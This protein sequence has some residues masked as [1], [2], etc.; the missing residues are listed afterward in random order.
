MLTLLGCCRR[1]YKDYFSFQRG[2]MEQGRMR[3]ISPELQAEILEWLRNNDG[4]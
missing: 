3:N 1:N 2:A 4:R